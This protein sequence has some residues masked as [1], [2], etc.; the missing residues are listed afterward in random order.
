MSDEMALAML[1]SS[2]PAPYHSLLVQKVADWQL[3]N[4]PLTVDGIC[5]YLRAVKCIGPPSTSLPVATGLTSASRSPGWRE[6]DTRVCDY[7]GKTGHLR[8]F[9][10]KHIADEATAKEKAKK[11][12]VYNWTGSLATVLEDQSL[13]LPLAVGYTNTPGAYHI[14][15]SSSDTPSESSAHPLLS[16]VST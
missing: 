2:L 6:K 4:K 9:C 11:S 16:V 3:E 1:E 8:Q 15:G 14:Q 10:H 5:Y 7:C 12:S 13:P